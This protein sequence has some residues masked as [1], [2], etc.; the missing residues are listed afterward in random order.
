[1]FESP[2]IVRALIFLYFKMVDQNIFLTVSRDKF[3]LS[4][5]TLQQFDFF[6]TCGCSL[7][8]CGVS[9]SLVFSSIVS[10]SLV[11]LA[12]LSWILVAEIGAVY[13]AWATIFW[14]SSAL[15]VILCSS[16]AT[17]SFTVEVI[18]LTSSTTIELLLS[19]SYF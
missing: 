11:C 4:Q 12:S 6:I 9:L 15:V 10:L 14:L 16:G 18:C 2:Q 7:S 8:N 19:F 1:M 5:K 13:G 17:I 3:N